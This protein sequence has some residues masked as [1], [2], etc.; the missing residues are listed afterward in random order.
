M[1]FETL[2]FLEQI[3]AEDPGPLA[4]ALAA[5]DR[6][7]QAAEAAEKAEAE[8][9]RAAA[10]D[11]AEGL[12][13]MDRQ[14]GHPL[15]EI[16]RAQADA[17][18]A[19]DEVTD[20]SA[21]LAKAQ[22]KLDQARHNVEFFAARMQA[23]HDSVA[24]MATATGGEDL[25]GPAKAA[26]AEFVARSRAAWAAAQAG[27]QGRAR[28]FARGGVAARSDTDHAMCVECAKVGA[29]AAESALIHLDPSPEPVPPGWMPSQPYCR[30][31]GALQ[32]ACTC[33]AGTRRNAGRYQPVRAGGRDY[34]EIR[35][36]AGST[37]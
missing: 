10:L 22:G 14:L 36:T 30:D 17:A 15:A 7:D 27:Q 6:K 20:L 19:L 31:C 1:S 35:R 9:R 24:R 37:A 25:L 12:A 11:R 8:A 28:P 5:S 21:R 33:P 4:R 18:A 2:Q 3:A 16:Q 23:A 34:G 26:H 29:S 32:G 13:L